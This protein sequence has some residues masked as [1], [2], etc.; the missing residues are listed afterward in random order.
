M[1]DYKVFLDATCHIFG[2]HFPTCN[3][4]PR[5]CDSQLFLSESEA[6]EHDILCLMASLM[7]TKYDK[8]WEECNFKLAVAVIL[9][10]MFRWIYL[11]ITL[12][13]YM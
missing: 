10:T 12:V 5:V 9:D 3:V 2:I 1:Y 4:F 11:S 6:S 8:Y 7:K 13:R